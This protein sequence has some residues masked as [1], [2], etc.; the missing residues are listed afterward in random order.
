MGFYN[1]KN[2]HPG[3]SLENVMIVKKDKFFVVFFQKPV[4]K[5]VVRKMVTTDITIH[6][7]GERVGW[8]CIN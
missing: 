2:G 4:K 8:V 6:T 7:V 1:K 3:Y 5:M